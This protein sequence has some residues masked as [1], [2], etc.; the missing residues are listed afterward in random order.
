MHLQG[1]F[2]ESYINHNLS[3]PCCVPDMVALDKVWLAIHVLIKC[4]IN[5]TPSNKRNK[6]P[7]TKPNQRIPVSA[8]LFVYFALY[9]F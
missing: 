8:V 7:K 4:F 2:R 1:V 9:F 6:K 3:H 5:V